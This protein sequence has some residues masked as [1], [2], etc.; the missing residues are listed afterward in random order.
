MSVICRQIVKYYRQQIGVAA[1][2]DNGQ[3]ARL[4]RFEHQIVTVACRKQI[5]IADVIVVMCFHVLFRKLIS[6]IVA[7]DCAI[8]FLS[9]VVSQCL[10]WN[11]VQENV[12]Y[13]FRHVKDVT[14]KAGHDVVIITGVNVCMG[15]HAIA[16]VWC[17]HPTM[18]PENIQNPQPNRNRRGTGIDDE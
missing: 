2:V 12:V 9:F 15:Q 6:T 3:N 14:K 18:A 10:H 11:F 7:D 5:T 17:H 4:V 1:A 16:F 13:S 8:E